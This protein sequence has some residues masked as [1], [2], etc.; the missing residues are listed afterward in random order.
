MLLVHQN[1]GKENRYGKNFFALLI[2]T[3]GRFDRAN[4]Q[5]RIC[6]I[7]FKVAAHNFMKSRSRD[8][9]AATGLLNWVAHY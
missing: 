4:K 6:H 7:H 3:L 5:K 1:T 2:R 8:G 9:L